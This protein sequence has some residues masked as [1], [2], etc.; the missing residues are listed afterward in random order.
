MDYGKKTLKE[1]IDKIDK[2]P[3]QELKEIINEADLKFKQIQFTRGVFVKVPI[4]QRANYKESEP[5]HSALVEY[6]FQ[7]AA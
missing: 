5:F 2:M 4:V 1:L 7:I 3:P 6:S